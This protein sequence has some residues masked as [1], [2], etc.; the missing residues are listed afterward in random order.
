[1]KVTIGNVKAFRYQIWQYVTSAC[2]RPVPQ[3]VA[4]NFVTSQ[5]SEGNHSVH[6]ALTSFMFLRAFIVPGE[7][8]ITQLADN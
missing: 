1:M 5:A 4:P 6:P 3:K 8:R 7:L 2:L